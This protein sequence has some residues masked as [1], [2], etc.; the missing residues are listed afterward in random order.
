MYKLR[1]AQNGA[2]SVTI[3]MSKVWICSTL[4]TLKY[5]FSVKSCT[6]IFKDVLVEKYFVLALLDQK[7]FFKG[8]SAFLDSVK[9]KIDQ[10]GLWVVM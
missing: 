3:R 2:G 10:I 8:K 1:F 5:K 4:P 7:I 9:S 6:V